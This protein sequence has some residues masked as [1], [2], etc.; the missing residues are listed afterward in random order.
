MAVTAAPRRR[1]KRSGPICSRFF[2]TL[3][4]SSTLS[5][6]SGIVCHTCQLSSDRGSTTFL[7]RPTSNSTKDQSRIDKARD[8]RRSLSDCTRGVEVLDKPVTRRMWRL[9][10]VSTVRRGFRLHDHWRSDTVKVA[11]NEWFSIDIQ[12]S[13]GSQCVIVTAQVTGEWWGSWNWL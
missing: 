6:G 1:L 13:L 2:P 12:I 5:T 9:A 11:R 4:L 10:E 8:T 7:S 3:P